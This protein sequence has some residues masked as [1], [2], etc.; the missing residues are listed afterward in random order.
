MV[1]LERDALISE[2]THSTV[3]INM[4]PSSAQPDGSVIHSTT[5]VLLESQE[6][7][8][9]LTAL[10]MLSAED[11]HQTK[12]I[13]NVTSLITH[14]KNVARMIRPVLLIETL[15]AE[16]VTLI[17]PKNSNATE[18]IQRAQ[19]ATNVTKTNQNQDVKNTLPLVKL[20][21]SQPINSHATTRP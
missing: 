10:A 19:N 4:I 8:T 15:L 16:T 9:L 17:Q 14:A 12:S 18:P 7:D 6:R 5:N 3:V 2:M 1:P 21:L 13:G 11:H 20:A